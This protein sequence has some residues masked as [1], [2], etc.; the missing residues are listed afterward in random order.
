MRVTHQLI[1]NTVIRNVNRNL[2]RMTKYQDML[3]S[4]KRINKPSED[5][6]AIT[7]IMG[8]ITSLQQNTQ[9]Q[10]NIDAAENWIH[11]TE[12]ALAG[13]NDVLQRARELAVSGADGSKP[14]EARRAIAMEVDELIG[15]VVQLANSSIGGRYIFAGYKTTSP[16]FE[17]KATVS[18]I[19][20]FADYD[21]YTDSIE[22]DGSLVQSIQYHGD[23][24]K[25][26]WEI[27][28]N[29]EIT[30][31]L[32][33]NSLFMEIELEDENNTSF[34]ASIFAVLEKL[35]V[36]LYKN[37]QETINQALG[38]LSRCIDHILDKRSALGAISKGLE[39]TKN[40]T[41][42]EE[43]NLTKLRSHLEDIDFAET[44]M[45]FST[46]ETL[47]YASL[48]AGARIMVPSLIDFLR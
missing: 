45:Y 26:K 35:A 42:L 22:I 20:E 37:D 33:G 15:V 8:Y 16:P 41:T 25:I 24:G 11:T 34:N 36:G 28:P 13:I 29:V 43:L 27:A 40:K 23:E 47:Y 9:Y 32:D 3:S 48:S 39:I 21:P 18:E 1:A 4:G 44:F 12:D 17:R 7:R 31:N 2:A 5:P 19:L 14:P 10:R 46:M 6:V 38:D 30:G